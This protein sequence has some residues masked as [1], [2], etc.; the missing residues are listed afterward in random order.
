MSNIKVSD[1]QNI[2]LADAI[3]RCGFKRLD[4]QQ[5]ELT[6]GNK[7]FVLSNLVGVVR[8]IQVLE[9][10]I[11]AGS[12]NG[13]QEIKHQKQVQKKDDIQLAAD[14]LEKKDLDEEN[15]RETKALEQNG[16]HIIGEDGYQTSSTDYKQTKKSNKKSYSV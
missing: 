8:E 4:D 6:D 7:K 2:S 14:P 13:P 11:Q 5:F 12:A 10:N 9:E 15:A 3:C 16:F 1:G